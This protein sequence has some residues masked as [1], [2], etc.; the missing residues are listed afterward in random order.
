MLLRGWLNRP[1]FRDY[2]LSDPI[3]VLIFAENLRALFYSSICWF[4]E[5]GGGI[6]FTLTSLISRVLYG[7]LFRVDW[8]PNNL[9]D[10]PSYSLL[11]IIDLA[12]EFSCFD[13]ICSRWLLALSTF[14]RSMPPCSVLPILPPRRPVKSTEVD[15]ADALC[16]PGILGTFKLWETLIDELPLIMSL[17]LFRL[18]EACTRLRFIWATFGR[19]EFASL[20]Y[21]LCLL[22]S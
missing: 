10:W 1:A 19:F 3:Y 17:I 14:E 16:P 2:P 15:S 13:K 12:I 11:T 7:C 4:T 18:V 5:V 21:G 20:P 9:S 6:T 22:S 8:W